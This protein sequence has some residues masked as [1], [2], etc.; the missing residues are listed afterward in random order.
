MAV[1]RVKEA[2]HERARWGVPRALCE[3]ELAADG[4]LTGAEWA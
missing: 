1:L 4:R 2:L 3:W